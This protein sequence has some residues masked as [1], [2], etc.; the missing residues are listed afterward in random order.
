MEPVRCINSPRP[1]R[2]G[3][4]PCPLLVPHFAWEEPV[5]DK[6]D[7]RQSPPCSSASAPATSGT[8]REEG[9]Q[10]RAVVGGGDAL[11]GSRPRR[12]GWRVR[13]RVRRPRQPIL[14]WI[15]TAV[16][17]R[18]RTVSMQSGRGP[19]SG[20][21]YGKGRAGRLPPRI[22]NRLTDKASVAGGSLAMRLRP[23]DTG[24]LLGGKSDRSGPKGSGPVALQQGMRRPRSPDLVGGECR[25]SLEAN[26]AK[27]AVSP[28]ASV[29]PLAP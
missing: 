29:A 19:L 20:T 3:I 27:P 13:A 18:C 9:R 6:T 1:A 26:A 5:D 17:F 24:E 14:G 10:A 28:A 16:Q 4:E 25:R 8:A 15:V 23:I 2:C 12:L 21:P 7:N 11:A 22:G